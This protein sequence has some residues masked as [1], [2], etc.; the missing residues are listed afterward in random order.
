MAVSFEC[1]VG[2]N[3]VLPAARNST[4]QTFFN[5]M[6]F[7][8]PLE[9]CRVHV[10]WA[11]NQIFAC[12]LPAAA[13]RV[14]FCRLTPLQV[15]V[16]KAVLSHPDMENVLRVDEDCACGSGQTR[17]KCCFK[18]SV[19]YTWLRSVSSALAWHVAGVVWRY[20]VPAHTGMKDVLVM[21]E[22]CV[23]GNCLML[24]DGRYPWGGSYLCWHGGC[25]AHGLGVCLKH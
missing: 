9:T 19:C 20:V 2:Q 10:P 24:L 13:D 4:C 3:M 23:C 14:V 15:S 7:P 18:V 1:G 11:A 8:K 16:Y 6:F 21:S 17:G 12:P 5:F 25:V 22:E